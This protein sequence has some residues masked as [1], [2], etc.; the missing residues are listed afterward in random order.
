M[1]IKSGRVGVAIDQVDLY[2]RL[3]PTPWL[4]EQLRELLEVEEA[5]VNANQLARQELAELHFDEPIVQKPI[6]PITPVM[7][8]NE[9]EETQEEE[10]GTEVG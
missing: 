9:V 6:T 3:I 8:L 2:G 7:D 1:A 10:D 5:E 4:I